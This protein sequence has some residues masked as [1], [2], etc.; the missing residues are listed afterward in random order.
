[1]VAAAGAATTGVV[2]TGVVAGVPGAEAGFAKPW[3]PC[4]AGFEASTVD[5]LVAIAAAAIASGCV[6]LP[7]DAGTPT[8][9]VATTGTAIATTTGAGVAAVDAASCDDVAGSEVAV[10]DA[11][12][13]S[14]AASLTAGFTM[15]DF[16]TAG[17]AGLLAIASVLPSAAMDCP[18]LG[19]ASCEGVFEAALEEAVLS[20][21]WRF[22][23]AADGSSGRGC[24]DGRSGA[25]GRSL[26]AASATLPSI[27]AEKLSGADGWSVRADRAGAFGTD[28]LAA[29]SDVTL[30]TGGLSQCFDHPG[31]QGPGHTVAEIKS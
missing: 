31:Q 13:M 19:C 5:M 2:S 14:G 22:S 10:S 6:V 29:V 9:S 21:G 24:G 20:R 27:S 15:P 1:V 26:P 4:A 11:T 28:R 7:G 16:A 25:A 12:T 18:P 3:E 17:F 8:A 30:N 23:D